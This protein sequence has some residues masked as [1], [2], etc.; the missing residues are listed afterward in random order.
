VSGAPPTGEQ[1]VIR[2]GTQVAMIALVGATL[3]EYRVGDRDVIDGFPL[4]ERSSAGRGQV[5]VPWPNRLADGSYTFG[6]RSTQAPVNEP[7]RRNAIHGLIRWMSW[8]LVT[9]ESD[10]VTLECTLWPQPGYEWPISTRV[11]YGLGPDGLTVSSEVTNRGDAPAPLGV[12][13][14]PYV[15]VGG[16]VDAA[17]LTVP[18]RTRLLADERGLPTGSADVSGTEF[19]FREARIVGPLRLDTA[20]SDLVRGEDGKAVASLTSGNG[21]TRVRVWVDDAYGYLMVYTGDGVEPDRRR[22]AVAIEPMTCPPDAFRSGTDIVSL[23]EGE[24]WRGSWG[25][26]PS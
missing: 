7:E 17:S 13:F 19:D 8:D 3:R 6:G 24:T 2:L 23:A 22:R 18:A 9:L 26:D 5:L 16:L 1:Y 4:N 10:A 12:G 11:T 15:T 14:H 20:Y 25:I 21:T